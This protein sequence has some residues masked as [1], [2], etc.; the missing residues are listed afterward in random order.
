MEAIVENNPIVNNSDM[1]EAHRAHIVKLLN[2]NGVC[3]RAELAKMTGLTQASITKITA[4]LIDEGILSETGVIKGNGNR[5]AIGL[6]LN[7]EK[8]LIIAVKFSRYVITIGVFDISG[9]YYTSM[10]FEFVEQDEPADVLGDIKKNIRK[11][12]EEYENVV[13]IGMA[14]PGPYL[15]YKGH[16]AIISRLSAWNEVNFEK[17]FKDEFHIPVFIEQDAN[18]GAMAEWWFGDHKR[19]ITSLAYML[20]GEG[21]GSG[22]VVENN[23]LLGK[24]GTA[25]EIGHVSIDINGPRCECGNYGCLEL[26]CSVPVILQRA[27]QEIPEIFDNDNHK[28]TDDYNVIFNAA[29]GGNTDAMKLLKQVAKYI[30]YGCVTLINAYNP[31]IIVIGD[32]LAKA[33]D[34]LLPVVLETV[35]KRAIPELFSEVDIRFSE[36]PI[37]PTLYGAAAIA[38][39]KVLSRPSDY[40]TSIHS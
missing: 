7:S 39:D 6:Q 13:A 5:R 27:K 35:K 36:L 14:V 34:I 16:I 2:R 15:K 9:K 33:G 20:M 19:P 12:L 31:D 30:A 8:N 11:Y 17:E 37:D 32:V 18:A 3:S 38:T 21:V 26:Y 29:R 23:L 22:I 28:R 10:E 4:A 24:L 25:S 1:N 40:L